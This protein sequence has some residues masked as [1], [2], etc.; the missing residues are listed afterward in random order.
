MADKAVNQ[1]T[2][3][4]APSVRP[5]LRNWTDTSAV[6]NAPAN[7]TRLPMIGMAPVGCTM[8][9]TPRNPN[10]TADQRWMPAT[11]RSRSTDRIVPKIGT[12]KP[13]AV[14]CASGSNI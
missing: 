7:A 9:I 4:P 11:S 2:V 3:V 5:R 8:T 1:K 12:L 14:A 6:N 13:I 10:K